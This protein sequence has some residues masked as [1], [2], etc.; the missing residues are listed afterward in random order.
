MRTEQCRNDG[1]HDRRIG[2]GSRTIEMGQYV[3]LDRPQ[4]TTSA[5]EPLEIDS[6]NKL[7]SVKKGPFR[8]NRS[9]SDNCFDRQR[10]NR[11]TVSVGRATVAP[12]ARVTPTGKGVTQ[13]D[14]TKA[15]NDQPHAKG[16]NMAGENVA[17]APH[18]YA[19]DCEVRLVGEGDNIE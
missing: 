18:E 5:A 3:Y 15:Q 8:G 14:N 7:V 13:S 6:Y 17:Y 11:N 10:G 16:N 4:R 1:D 9:I 12:T 2:T 19:V